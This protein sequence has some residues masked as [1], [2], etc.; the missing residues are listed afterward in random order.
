MFYYKTTINVRIREGG[1]VFLCGSSLN[2][3]TRT[4]ASCSCS[5]RTPASSL[6][7][8]TY[9]FLLVLRIHKQPIFF[10]YIHTH[11]H[12]LCLKHFSVGK[13]ML[14]AIIA[15]LGSILYTRTCTNG[16]ISGTTANFKVTSPSVTA[17][18]EHITLSTFTCTVIIRY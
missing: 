6:K 18:Q 14:W 4:T 12:T 9:V 15:S 17:K 1:V 13:F 2:P 5:E 7:S 11:T 3:R 10:T 8:S 16:V